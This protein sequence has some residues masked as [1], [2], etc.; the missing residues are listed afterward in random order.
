[1][2]KP[3]GRWSFFCVAYLRSLMDTFPVWLVSFVLLLVLWIVT[4]SI[5][6]M[7]YGWAALWMLLGGIA[8][9]LLAFPIMWMVPEDERETVLKKF[10][11]KNDP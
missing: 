3:L 8:L 6:G 5:E 4:I 2:S 9:F 11:P 10:G 7:L 1:M